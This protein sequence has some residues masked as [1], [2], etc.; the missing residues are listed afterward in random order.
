MVRQVGAGDTS[1]ATVVK[2]VAKLMPED[3][4]EINS[5]VKTRRKVAK[6]SRKNVESLKYLLG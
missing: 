3:E 5:T 2:R 1:I 6:T 4:E